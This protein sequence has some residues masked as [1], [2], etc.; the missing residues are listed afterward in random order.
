[1]SIRAYSKDGNPI[2]KGD[3]GTILN[4]N[5][6]TMQ[7]L[8]SEGCPVKRFTIKES[9]WGNDRIKGIYKLGSA[10]AEVGRSTDRLK[11]G[12]VYI[13]VQMECTEINDGRE[14]YILI[15][16]GNILPIISYEEKQ[17]DTPVRQ[18]RD[19][20][21]IWWRSVVIGFRSRVLNLNNRRR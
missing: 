15:R 12:E 6:A 18:F 1:M 21:R 3:F 19:L 10:T 17:I 7:S 11:D 13:S 4:P 9:W 14:L 2:E 5:H 8:S 20:L 16:S